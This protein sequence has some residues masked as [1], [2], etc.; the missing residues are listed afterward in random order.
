MHIT[1][2]K[3]FISADIEGTAGIVHWDE[4]E[5]S[6]PHDYDYFADQMTREVRAACE[7]AHDAGAEEIVVKDAHDS[8]RN[9]DPR[10]LPEYAR[11]FRGW[12][13]HP[14]SMMFGLDKSF[15]GVVFTG[16][17]SAA[18]MPTNPLSHT[19][20]TQ[21]NH[22]LING[23]LASELMMNCLTASYEGV[24]VYAVAG[25]AGL[26]RWINGVNP[27]I[28]TVPTNEGVGSGALTIHPDVAVR[29]IR[30]AVKTALLERTREECMFPMPEKFD[31]EINFKE[32]FRARGGSFYPGA[33]QKDARTVAFSS[34]DYFEVLR[35]I[36]FV[37]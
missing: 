26:C 5:K 12:G 1:M 28:I 19:M 22:V 6:K 4:T 10:K 8:G 29:S 23:E 20:N 31:V 11:V 18:E 36:H 34:D 33:V 21:N 7:G 25:D 32:H 3:I 24:P 37:L 15:D 17:H 35:F 14:Y 9:I 27:R 30:E 16:Y 13:R 2:K